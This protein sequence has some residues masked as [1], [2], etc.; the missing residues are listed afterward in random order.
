MS[1][2]SSGGFVELESTWDIGSGP[3]GR[4][5]ITARDAAKR[6]NDHRHPALEIATQGDWLNWLTEEEQPLINEDGL[7]IGVLDDVPDN[8]Q[9]LRKPGDLAKYA[10]L[11][12]AWLSPGNAVPLGVGT[13]CYVDA[14]GVFVRESQRFTDLIMPL[15]TQARVDI[16]PPA[17]PLR[18][19]SAYVDLGKY[20]NARAR[21]ELKLQAAIEVVRNF[22]N[23]DNAEDAEIT[24][25]FYRR[26]FDENGLLIEE[27]KPVPVYQGGNANEDNPLE[28]S[29]A[30]AFGA[31]ELSAAISQTSAS[32][33]LP[34]VPT[35]LEVHIY[36]PDNLAD[37]TAHILSVTL[38]VD[39][40]LGLSPQINT[41]DDQRVYFSSPSEV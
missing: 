32:L 33:A 39:Q 35:F 34:L 29:F 10:G 4:D 28:L 36:G 26:D 12:W 14:A 2:K 8:P 3:R 17:A 27:L 21:A 9:L 40:K 16:P 7:A 20:V 31:G 5:G 18:V 24:L 6:Y 13:G 25:R 11:L 19:G 1:R 41:I 23:I 22:V 30:Y 37:V 38:E 15:T